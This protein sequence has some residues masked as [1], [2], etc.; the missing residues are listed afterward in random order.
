MSSVVR[1]R[2][3]FVRSSLS[4]AGPLQAGKIEEFKV[5][6]VESPVVDPTTFVTTQ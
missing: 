5:L 2:A 4:G 1:A 3:H 6:Y